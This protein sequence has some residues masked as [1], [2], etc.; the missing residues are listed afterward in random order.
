MNPHMPA[1]YSETVSAGEEIS[2]ADIS[3]REERKLSQ[4]HVSMFMTQ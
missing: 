1:D 4:S 2:T 3:G